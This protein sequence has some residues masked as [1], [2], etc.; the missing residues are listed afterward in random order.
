MT[1]LFDLSGPA[2]PPAAGGAAASIVVLL[3]GYGADGNDL[4]GLAPH[5][6]QVL[7]KTLFVS[8]HAPFPCEMGGPGRQWFSLQDR[9]PSAVLAGVGAVQQIL[10][11]FLDDMLARFKLPESRLALV[12]FSQG[13][14]MA[15]HAAPRRA[16][17]CAGIVGFSGRLL[18]D[19]ALKREAVSRP[20]VLLIHGDA[21]QLVPIGNLDHA[22]EGLKA[23]GIA[24]EAHR[25]AGLDHGIDEEGLRLATAFL[26]RVL[27]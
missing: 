10:N 14:M 11:A 17:P 15:L 3:H 24:V 20:P 26:K 25:R 2:V 27:A 13:T 6:G 7:P 9:T 4:I 1:G 5:L 21:D 18:D 8:P 19:G 12:G 23:A 22:V 16:T